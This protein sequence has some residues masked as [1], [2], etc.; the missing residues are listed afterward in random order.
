M[1]RKLVIFKVVLRSYMYSTL[2]PRQSR[3]TDRFMVSLFRC[4]AYSL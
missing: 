2:K 4:Q 1:T 3:L